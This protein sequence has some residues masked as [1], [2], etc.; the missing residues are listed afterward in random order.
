VA[1]GFSWNLQS[2]IVFR[3]LQGFTG[4]V[5]I[6]M[7]FNLV[8]KLLQTAR[9]GPAFAIFG[10][11][12]TFAPAIGPALGGWLTDSYGWPA[13]FYMNLVPGALLLAAVGWGLEPGKMRLHLLRHGDWP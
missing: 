13:I 4:G 1:C 2:M 10:M 7:A 11:T 12:A 5:L 6:P 9:R 8:L 3:A